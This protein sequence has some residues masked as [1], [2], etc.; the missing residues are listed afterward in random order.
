MGCDIHMYAEV[1]NAEGIWEKVG[2]VFDNSYYDPE[3]ETKTFPDGYILNAPKTDHPYDDRHYLLFAILADVRNGYGFAGIVTHEPVKPL[4]ANRG[5]P[6]DASNEYK[7]IAS[8]WDCDGHSHTYAYLHELQKVDWDSITVDRVGILTEKEYNRVLKTGEN[9]QDW[10]GDVWGG[11]TIKVS[12]A[13]Y[14]ANYRKALATLD[15]KQTVYIQWFWQE[16]LSDALDDFIGTTIP[17]LA[18]LGKP[19][20]VR[21]VFFF[22]N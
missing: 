10:S 22:D 1:R 8:D 13:A 3:R 2:E 12:P 16:K 15:T 17:A 20:D 6:E 14:E 11:N 4:F 18:K 21:I 9:P 19:E 7:Q 5:I